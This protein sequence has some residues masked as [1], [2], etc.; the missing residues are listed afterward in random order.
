MKLCNSSV[1]QFLHQLSQLI[2]LPNHGPC[3]SRSLEDHGVDHLLAMELRNW[4]REYL[5]ADISL[6][7]LRDAGSIQELAK[8][9]SNKSQLVEVSVT[10]Q[11]T[12]KVHKL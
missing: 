10:P 4:I 11:L 12:G 7:V 6:L 3:A 5:Q 8:I 9:I 2:D 1:K